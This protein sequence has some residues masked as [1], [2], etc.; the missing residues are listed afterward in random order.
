MNKNELI[1]EFMSTEHTDTSKVILKNR[2]KDLDQLVRESR[3]EVEQLNLQLQQKQKDF[4][5]LSE[6]LQGLLELVVEITH[7]QK[8]QIEQ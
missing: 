5:S 4:F 2:I 3:N 1:Q 7:E 8:N 6:K